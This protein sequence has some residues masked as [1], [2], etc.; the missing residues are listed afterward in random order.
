M[1][2]KNR[3]ANEIIPIMI[4]NRKE[5]QWFVEPFVGGS[6]VIDK[7]GGNRLASDNN[8]YLIELYHKLQNGYKPIDF[9]LTERK[10]PFIALAWMGCKR[11][12]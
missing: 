3:I 1:G 8:K 2:S 9:I 11:L 5:S 12:F 6:N 7:V 4:K 10:N